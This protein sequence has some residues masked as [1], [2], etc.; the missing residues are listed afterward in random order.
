MERSAA[1]PDLR[2]HR[3][4][5]MLAVALGLCLEPVCAAQPTY[6]AVLSRLALAGEHTRTAFVVAALDAL[7]AQH[8]GAMA[9]ARGGAHAADASWLAAT[10]AYVATLRTL[11]ERARAGARVRFVRERDGVL[12]VL[13][14]HG[15]PRQFMLGSP[16]PHERGALERDVVARFCAIV[17]CRANVPGAL[18]V[19][20]PSSAVPAAAPLG[21]SASPVV[22]PVRLG[23]GD[24][25]TCP[26]PDAR[27][28]RLAERACRPLL[29][30]LR[31]VA[32][33]LVPHAGTIDWQALAAPRPDGDAHRLVFNRSGDAVRLP[34]PSLAASPATLAAAVGW[35][36]GVLAGKV[37]PHALTPP[38][39]MVYQAS[40]AASGAP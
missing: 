36:R 22:R 33:A 10:R 23:P 16:R 14:G 9:A 21:A 11:G 18:F 27:H 31:A 25:L 12:R 2:G 26:G 1:R 28:R 37:A 17:A 34:L 4:A 15:A 6:D 32:R 40:L 39:R 3:R 29:A 38:S 30:E 20:E 8:L 35:M 19:H 5:A 24:G 7:I 13:V